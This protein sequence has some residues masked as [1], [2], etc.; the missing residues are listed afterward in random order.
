MAKKPDQRAADIL[1]QADELADQL[2]RAWVR[3]FRRERQ[4]IRSKVSGP[5]ARSGTKFWDGGDV[6]NGVGLAQDRTRSERP[7]T[8]LLEVKAFNPAKW[9]DKARWLKEMGDETR[10][11]LSRFFVAYFERGGMDDAAAGKLAEALTN[12][13][14]DSTIEW[15]EGYLDRLGELAR[16]AAEKEGSTIADVV[17]AIEVAF[18]AAEEHANAVAISQ[19]VGSANQAQ[20]EMVRKLGIKGKKVWFCLAADTPVQAVGVTHAARRWFSGEMVELRLAGSTCRFGNPGSPDRFLT[21][22]PNHPV[23]TDRGWVEAGELDEGDRLIRRPPFKIVAVGQPDVEHRPPAIVEVFQ[24]ATETTHLGCQRMMG[25]PVDFDGHRFDGD[26][27][28]V[29]TDGD[30]PPG[31]HPSF[32]EPADEQ[33]FTLTDEQ[34]A[35]LTQEGTFFEERRGDFLALV[36]RYGGGNTASN[37]LFRIAGSSQHPSFGLS[38]QRDSEVGQGGPDG[39]LGHLEVDGELASRFAAQVTLDEVVGVRRIPFSGHV[40]DLSTSSHWFLANGYVIHNSAM[41]ERVRPQHRTPVHGQRRDIDEPFKVDGVDMD[42]P[43]D[44]SAPIGL[45]VNCRCVILFYPATE[46]GEPVSGLEAASAYI[47]LQADLR[48]QILDRLE[49]KGIRIRRVRTPEGARAYDQPIGSLIKPDVVPR[50]TPKP[51]APRVRVA[52]PL[53]PIRNFSAWGDRADDIETLAVQMDRAAL[54]AP[55]AGWHYDTANMREDDPALNTLR[56]IYNFTDEKS[57]LQVVITR[58]EQVGAGRWRVT[59]SVKNTRA[60]DAYQRSAGKWEKIVDVDADPPHAFHGLIQLWDQYQ[61]RGFGERL[62]RHEENAYVALGAERIDLLAGLDGGGYAWARAGFDWRFSPGAYRAPWVKVLGRLIDRQEQARDDGDTDTVDLLEGVISRFEAAETQLGKLDAD[63]PPLKKGDV[64]SYLRVAQEPGWRIP[65]DVDLPTPYEIARLATAQH[66]QLGKELMR[67]AE[68]EARKTLVPI[69]GV[70]TKAAGDGAD[71]KPTRREVFLA[72]A[73]EMWWRELANR[74][75]PGEDGLDWRPR[76]KVIPSTED[77]TPPET[78]VAGTMIRH[79]RTPEGARH[80]DQPIGSVIVPDV[81]RLPDVDV[82]V[83]PDDEAVPEPGPSPAW[84]YALEHAV[85][86]PDQASDRLRFWLTP[87]GRYAPVSWHED[88]FPWKPM[89]YR[90]FVER[91]GAVRI[92]NAKVELTVDIMGTLTRE[93]VEAL[94][95]AAAKKPSVVIFAVRPDRADA[96]TFEERLKNPDWTA[97]LAAM[98]RAAAFTRGRQ[99]VAPSRLLEFRTDRADETKGARHVRTP[100]GAEVYDQPIGS[101]IVRDLPDAPDVDIEVTRPRPRPEPVGAMGSSLLDPTNAPKK[102]QEKVA[103]AMAAINRVH[104]LGE[105]TVRQGLPMETLKARGK[106]GALV[107]QGSFPRHIAIRPGAPFA[108]MTTTHEYGH[109]LDFMLLGGTRHSWTSEQSTVPSTPLNTEAWQ[110]FHKALFDS[111]G[112]KRIFR[113]VDVEYRDREGNI[114]TTS[115][116]LGDGSKQYFAKKIEQFARAYAQWITIR[117]QDEQMLKELRQVQAEDAKAIPGKDDPEVR[118]RITFHGQWDDDDFEPIAAALDD[119]FREEGWMA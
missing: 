106:D 41:D 119:I 45:W 36:G 40:Y 35:T 26:V 83:D 92:T 86:V 53:P 4:V 91:T 23:L 39:G 48:A 69:V 24:A 116:G 81:T 10:E 29:R 103:R 98:E 58:A 62:L 1:K 37:N 101:V 87:D 72:R 60:D 22:T 11:L 99:R 115:G 84:E 42:Y 75:D 27:D 3:L 108:A 56:A 5:K 49:T 66:K 59:G 31:I 111:E 33:V 112:Y 28:V 109:L 55:H 105:T 97:A 47:G 9:I 67:G 93:Q 68:W 25:V 63:L 71:R 12:E 19:A 77:P 8:V 113:K 90:D 117:S 79:V 118:N 44:R 6:G 17:K 43:G 73:A 114:V 64:F 104:G 95:A 30:L 14:V 21:I 94:A 82:D 80:Y 110:R 15:H 52:R 2:T 20:I 96:E 70:E 78:K 46:S 74:G 107:I 102:V 88:A 54:R 65:D 57:G 89:G 13:R 50:I 38:S 85:D 32:A 61:G 51:D 18:D 34:L 100:E 76:G 7:G 16:A